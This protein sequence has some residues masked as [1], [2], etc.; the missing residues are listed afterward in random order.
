MLPL[1]D[2][3]VAAVKP[4][5][6]RTAHDGDRCRCRVQGQSGQWRHRERVSHCLCSR[7]VGRR[8]DDVLCAAGIA[9]P[10]VTVT[11]AVVPGRMDAGLM[12]PVTPLGAAAVRETLFL[13]VPLSVT[14]SVK[15]IVLPAATSRYWLRTPAQNLSPGLVVLD[16]PPHSAASTVP[17]TEPRPVARLYDAP[18]A[19]KPVTPGTLLLP[20]GVAMEGTFV[21]V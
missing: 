10:V 12:L 15:V 5:C 16:P 9:E 3:P 7:A 11:V 6:G 13:A 18:L 21:R 4:T 17:S 2:P 14:L 1:K 20:E 8:D 19:V